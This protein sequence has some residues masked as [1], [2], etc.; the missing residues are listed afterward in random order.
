MRLPSVLGVCLVV[1]SLLC[2]GIGIADLSLPKFSAGVR[3]LFV[4]SRENNYGSD[5]MARVLHMVSDVTFD[6]VTLGIRVGIPNP[7]NSRV[8]VPLRRTELRDFETGV[9]KIKAGS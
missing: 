2:P 5:N 6:S 7:D 1:G 3:E 9:Q 8:E 4:S